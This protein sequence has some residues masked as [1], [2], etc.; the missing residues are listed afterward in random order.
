MS[1]DEE[2]IENTDD[3]GTATDGVTNEPRGNPEVDQDALDKGVEQL[4]RVKP[5]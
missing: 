5:Y 1:N 4:D 2:H 3:A